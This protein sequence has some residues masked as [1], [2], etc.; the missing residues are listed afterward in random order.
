MFE[1]II[2][3]KKL[4]TRL[5]IN[6]QV[7]IINVITFVRDCMLVVLLTRAPRGLE[8]RSICL[9]RRRKEWYENE[10]ENIVLFVYSVFGRKIIL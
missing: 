10:N 8:P 4:T 5:V 7:N 2:Y 9:L 6:L 3:L 1:K